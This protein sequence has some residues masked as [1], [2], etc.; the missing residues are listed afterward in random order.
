MSD[1]NT[2]IKIQ[3]GFHVGRGE[4]GHW[5]DFK[6]PNGNGG[7]L[8]VENLQAGH[9]CKNAICDWIDHQLER[10]CPDCKGHGDRDAPFSGSD[11]SCPTCDGEGTVS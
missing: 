7:C 6:A 8:N 1:R 10:A 9:I 3:A 4:D 11:P 2:R 5:I